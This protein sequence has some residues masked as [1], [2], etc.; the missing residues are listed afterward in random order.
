M[1]KLNEG[2]ITMWKALKST[3]EIAI[4]YK[5][6][7]QAVKKYLNRQGISTAKGQFYI[8]C[9]VCGKKM[10]R[11]RRY[12]RKARHHFCSFACYM[13]FIENPKY[14]QYRQGQK[15]ARKILTGFGLKDFVAHHRD[16]DDKNNDMSNLLAFKSQADHMAYHRFAPAIAFNPITQK[17]ELQLKDKD[18]LR[19]SNFGI[20]VFVAS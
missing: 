10:H 14:N 4:K 20:K 6:T 3:G 13:K 9:E 11:S 16:G 5:V 17:W 19:G 8:A 12:I 2:A 1:R 18:S 15:I 7:R